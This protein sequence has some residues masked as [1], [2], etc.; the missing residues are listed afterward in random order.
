M[1]EFLRILADNSGLSPIQP[2]N[3]PQ[4]NTDSGQVQN[5][6]GVT[7]GIIGALALLIIVVS[8]LRYITSA[9]DP[10]KTAKARNGIIYSLVGLIVA[11]AAESIVFFVVGRLQ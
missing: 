4:A 1:I 6:L 2:G 5:I 8:G 10:E 11:I 3:L 7:F 9:G